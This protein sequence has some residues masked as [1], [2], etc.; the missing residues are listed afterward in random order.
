MS[1]ILKERQLMARAAAEAQTLGHGGIVAVVEFIGM[2]RT[3]REA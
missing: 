2:G 1:Q 3:I